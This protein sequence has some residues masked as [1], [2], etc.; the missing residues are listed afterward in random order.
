MGK[1]VNEI[2]QGHILHKVFALVIVYY[3][4]IIYLQN[5]SYVLI[6]LPISMFILYALFFVGSLQVTRETYWILL[7][8]FFASCLSLIRGDFT[9]L[10]AV[11]LF[12][13]L[14][15][16]V[17][18]FHLRVS[19]RLVNT[20]FFLSVLLS[21]PLFYSGYSIYGFLPGQGGFNHDEFLSGRVS[22]FPNVTTSIYFSFIVFLLNYFFNKNRYERLFFFALSLYFIYFGIS[23]TVMLVLFFVIFFSWILKS[24]PL[25]RSWFYQVVVPTILILFPILMVVFIEEI[26]YFLLSLNNE[27]IS[28]YFFRGYHSV[29]E[30]LNDIART[31]IWKEHIR[32]F[33]EHPWGLSPAEVELY[34]DKSLHLS[35]GG[36]ES[37]LTRILVRFGFAAL[38]FYMFIFSMLNRAIHE[39]D[40]YLYIFTYI[41][42]FIALSYGSFFA[43]YNVLFL[44]FIS[45]INNK[46]EESER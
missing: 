32:L 45:S 38:F 17:N 10:I 18:N 8:I 2:D 28:E 33:V 21:V 14:I 39:R 27:V 40:D 7:F 37:F 25:R 35:D 5:P 20:L 3:W 26:I 13:L 43:A 34:V 9:T 36:S 24:F 15:A 42:I 6:T 1:T 41:F 31:N 12:G 44:I 16:V 19:L 46:K 23:R 29:D 11:M 30:I 22:M 4:G